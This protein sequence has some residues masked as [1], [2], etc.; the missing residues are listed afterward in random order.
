MLV[1]S[2]DVALVSSTTSPDSRLARAS[3][4]S[5]PVLKSFCKKKKQRIE[6]RPL[7][8]KESVCARRSSQTAFA[9]IKIRQK[10]Q[11]SALL[12]ITENS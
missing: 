12:A 7:A 9:Q 11:N 1:E 10:T 6:T 8:L 5:R 4:R 2:V 3:L